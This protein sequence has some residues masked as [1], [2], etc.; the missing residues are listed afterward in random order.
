MSI[1]FDQSNKRTS[2]QYKSYLTSKVM[3]PKINP[4]SEI[5]A[6]R[7][8]RSVLLVDDDYT[9]NILCETII[10]RL[11]IAEEIEV[12]DNGEDAFQFIKETCF[13]DKCPELILLDINMPVLNGLEFL[14]AYRLLNS[15]HAK[16]ILAV[17]TSSSFEGDIEA[18]RKLGVDDYI[19]KPLTSQKLLD[20]IEKHSVKLEAGSGK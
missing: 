5:V 6:K 8:L 7:K 15:F 4:K 14:E 12:V 10:K 13:T 16:V 9:S 2:N 3:V 19:L 18:A 17:L 11:D 20:L 1:L